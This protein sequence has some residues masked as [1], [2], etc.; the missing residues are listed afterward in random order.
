[1]RKRGHNPRNDEEF[2]KILKSEMDIIAQQY[3]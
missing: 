3:K 1:M 2:K